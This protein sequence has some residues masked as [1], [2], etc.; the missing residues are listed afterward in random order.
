MKRLVI[1]LALIAL[2]SCSCQQ[3]YDILDYQG[4][5]IE[6]HCT[7]NE[8]Y[9][10]VIKSNKEALTLEIVEPV[11]LKGVT[12]QIGNEVYASVNDV[13]IKIKPEQIKGICALCHMFSLEE[14]TMTAAEKNGEGSELTFLDSYGAYTLTLGK[15]SVPSRV[16]IN[17]EKYSYNVIIDGIKI[18]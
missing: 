14:E 3:K 2:L 10:V 18:E 7:V 4:G 5:N 12:F 16:I 11:R 8:K 1:F 9:S 6:A 17:G 13:K 15:G